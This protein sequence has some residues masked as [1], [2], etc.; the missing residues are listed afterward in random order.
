MKANLYFRLVGLLLLITLSFSFELR[1]LHREDENTKEEEGA[2]NDAEEENSPKEKPSDEPIKARDPQ[3]INITID[4]DKI[5]NEL[6]KTIE[7][8]R[9]D[10]I[11]LS[12]S[13]EQLKLS[14]VFDENVTRK[15]FNIIKSFFRTSIFNSNTRKYAQVGKSSMTIHFRKEGSLSLEIKFNKSDSKQFETK[16]SS[17]NTIIKLNMTVVDYE[18]IAKEQEKERQKELDKENPDKKK[19]PI[20]TDPDYSNPGDPMKYDYQGDMD[21]IRKNFDHEFHW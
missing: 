5:E 12:L 11:L 15:D 21:E 19:K 10:K 1:F 13:G 3:N 16:S 2:G 14:P 9:K 6:E 4:I 8:G 7:C 20:S 17:F 18:K